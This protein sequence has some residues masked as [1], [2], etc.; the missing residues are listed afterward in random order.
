MIL[1]HLLHSREKLVADV[2]EFI[3]DQFLTLL[4]S[5]SPPFVEIVFSITQIACEYSLIIIDQVIQN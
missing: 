4:N 3:I 1:L 2:A 5:H